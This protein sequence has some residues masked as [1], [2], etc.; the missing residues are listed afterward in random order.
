M[1]RC[2]FAHGPSPERPPGISARICFSRF[3]ART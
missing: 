3:N 1:I 2:V